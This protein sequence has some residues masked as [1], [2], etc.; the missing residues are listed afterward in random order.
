MSRRQVQQNDSLDMLLDTMCNTFGG[1]ILI[2]L[3]IALLAR[4]TK[5]AEA[6]QRR[7]TESEGLT[8]RQ[9]EQAEN[10]L[11]RAKSYQADLARRVN[12]PAQT[13]ILELVEE[14]ERLRGISEALGAAL[15]ATNQAANGSAVAGESHA[16]ERI[17]QMNAQNRAVERQLLE[18]RNLGASL[19]GRI[20]DLKRGLQDESNR[21]VQIT[22]RQV[23]RL[24]P[25]IEDSTSTKTHLYAIIRYGQLYPLYRY[26]NGQP[27]QNTVS[28]KWTQ[29][30]EHQRRIE[31]L[32]GRGINPATQPAALEQFLR[33]VPGDR[34]YLIFQVFQ[35]SFGT[36]NLIKEAAVRRHLEYTWEPRLNDAVLRLGP[37]APPP[38]PQR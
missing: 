25:P 21:L 35:D 22:A 31:P 9:I 36:F 16:L 32:P 14:R 10:D 30:N 5:T 13:A 27:E 6:D 23:Q 17:R 8:R 12:D 18:Q 33:E 2:A 19:L 37:A 11:I 20:A 34:V 3:L 28:L 7:L 4:D 1:I 29:E 15:S 24:H 26:R 38:P